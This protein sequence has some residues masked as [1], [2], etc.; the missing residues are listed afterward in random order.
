MGTLAALP[1]TNSCGVPSWTLVLYVFIACVNVQSC[2]RDHCFR[3]S[4]NMWCEC[5]I[6]PLDWGRYAVIFYLEILYL[7]AIWR[8]TLFIKFEPWSV[9]QAFG[10]IYG[11]INSFTSAYERYFRRRC[12]LQWYRHWT[13]SQQ[14][15]CREFVCVSAVGRRQRSHDI[16]WDFIERGIWR[17]HEKHCRIFTRTNFFN[18]QFRYSCIKFCI[19]VFITD[20]K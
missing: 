10:A 7:W 11:L 8:I 4:I 1:N 16:H 12:L 20:Q 17:V 6:D 3:Y 13:F 2:F 18:W 19:S 5:S 15:L 9:I 14:I